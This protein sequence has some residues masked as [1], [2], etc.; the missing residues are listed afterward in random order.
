[1]SLRSSFALIVQ[2]GALPIR[3][4]PRCVNRAWQ[5]G[6]GQT[7]M[8]AQAGGNVTVA[9]LR[10]FAFGAKSEGTRFGTDPQTVLTAFREGSRQKEDNRSVGCAQLD[11]FL[12]IQER[13]LIVLLATTIRPRDQNQASLSAN[14]VYL[15]GL[16]RIRPPNTRTVR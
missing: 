11:A 1:M 6:T 5:G 2:L 9:I 12:A 8:R 7:V 4:D 15:A 16:Q 3:K 14:D 10:M 13:I